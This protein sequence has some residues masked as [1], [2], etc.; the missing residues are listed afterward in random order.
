PR[1]TRR[2]IRPEGSE[3]TTYTAQSIVF[4]DSRVSNLQ[5]LIDGL[6]SGEVAYV[7]DPNSDG[8]QQI[9]DI[10]AA[11]NLAG[12][13]SVSIVAHGEPGEVALGSSS[14]TDA[15]LAA[16]AS[17]LAELGAALAPGGNIKLYGCDVAVGAA[18]QQFINDFS[19]FAGGA[20]VEAATH[21]VGSADPA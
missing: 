8:V 21:A 7:L 15:N 4:I 17:A 18:G 3:M 1:P 9:A 13:S 11:N 20:P 5:G 2:T 10:L 12:L 14:L 6:Q 19:T 16:H